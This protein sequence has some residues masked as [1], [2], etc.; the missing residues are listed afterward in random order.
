MTSAGAGSLVNTPIVLHQ[1]VLGV[2]ANIAGGAKVDAAITSNNY[3][4]YVGTLGQ[5]LPLNTNPAGT[6]TS[7]TRRS[8]RRSPASAAARRSRSGASARSSA[9]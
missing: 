9:T 3:K 7:T 6:P 4:N 5:V 2:R 1:F 8:T